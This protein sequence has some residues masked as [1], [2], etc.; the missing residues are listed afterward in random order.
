MSNS[1]LSLNGRPSLCAESSFNKISMGNSGLTGD[2]HQRLSIVG[3]GILGRFCLDL[4]TAFWNWD[5]LFLLII[6]RF[7]G[8]SIF[9]DFEIFSLFLWGLN[10]FELSVD[11]T[12]L[13]WMG[14][15]LNWIHLVVE[16][17]WTLCVGVE[18]V[19]FNLFVDIVARIFGGWNYYSGF[20]GSCEIADIWSICV[21]YLKLLGPNLAGPPARSHLLR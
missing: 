5:A 13:N 15:T 4:L 7:Q 8:G 9:F 11:W 10:W 20:L 17:K 3:R 19:L 6:R 21:L 2:L 14:T 1:H 18:I 16:K 12:E